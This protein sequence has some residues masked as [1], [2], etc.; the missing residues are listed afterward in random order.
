VIRLRVPPF[1][2]ARLFAA[3][4]AFVTVVAVL[5]VAP[6]HAQITIPP[7]TRVVE[8]LPVTIHYE[9]RYRRVAN[10]IAD[11]CRD[12]LPRIA[13]EQGLTDVHPIEIIV[14]SDAGV[15]RGR[16]VRELPEWGV[17]FALLDEQRILVDVDRA[18]RE[19]NSLDDIVPHEL[20]HLVLRQR[21][22]HAGFPIWFN[23]GLAQWQSGEWSM[24]DSWRMLEDVWEHKT[25]NLM[26]VTVS[27]PLGEERAQDAYRLSYVAFTELFSEGGF[28]QLPAFLAKVDH[29]GNFRLAF[30]GFWGFDEADYGAYL[31][32]QLEKRYRHNALAFETGPLLT[33]AAFLFVL[34]LIRQTVRKR[35]RFAE[36]D[37]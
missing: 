7:D 19:Y 1:R 12:N 27:Y 21:V 14:T 24:M 20:S 18:T 4:F 25:P 5:A 6:P 8:G 2:R 36:L 29:M 17:A 37:D 35:K 31:Q 26:D 15:R 11:L 22:P 23:E 16:S 3:A 33:F 13:S 28:Q 9:H 34:V 30:R 32:L 10:K